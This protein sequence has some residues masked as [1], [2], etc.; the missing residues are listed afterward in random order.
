[1]EITYMIL[2]D[3]WAEEKDAKKKNIWKNKFGLAVNNLNA[4]KNLVLMVKCT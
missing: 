2:C 1:M 4:M 3:V